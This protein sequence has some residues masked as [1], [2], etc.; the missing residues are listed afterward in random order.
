MSEHN[1]GPREFDPVTSSPG[2]DLPPFEN[3]DGEQPFEDEDEDDGEQLF[4]DNME[5]DYRAMPA[6]DRYELLVMS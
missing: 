2:R 6:L 1:R 4:G 3:E 5:D